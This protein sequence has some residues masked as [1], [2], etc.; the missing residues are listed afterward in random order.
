M[1]GSLKGRYIMAE[2]LEGQNGLDCCGQE[3]EQG[4]HTRGKSEGPDR[5]DIVP[6]RTPA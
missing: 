6:T 4:Y 2:G 1:V 5:L 3:V